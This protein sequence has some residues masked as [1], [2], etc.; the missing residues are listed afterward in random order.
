MDCIWV[1]ERPEGLAV[2][3]GVVPEIG[4]NDALETAKEMDPQGT[5]NLWVL[6]SVVLPVLSVARTYHE[7]WSLQAREDGSG[8]EMPV[9]VVRSAP[10]R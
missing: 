2:G 5:E 7:C 4:G 9:V 8:V 1:S 10:S 3:V 6:E